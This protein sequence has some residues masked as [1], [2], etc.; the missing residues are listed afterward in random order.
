VGGSTEPPKTY[1][2]RRFMDAQ[3]DVYTRALEELKAGR[4]QTHWM[5]YIFP[6]LAGLGSSATAQYYAIA[7]LEEARQYL[8]HPLL[9]VRLSACCAALLALPGSDI[10]AVLGHP[11]DLKLCSSMTLF[12][13]AANDPAIFDAVLKKFYA[14]RRD[15]LTL[16]MLEK[17]K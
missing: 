13:Q 6:Q 14:G 12:E 15:S 2:L 3:M 9:S 7:D 4:K 1:D 16:D 17:E 10:T 11:D 5:W 8:A